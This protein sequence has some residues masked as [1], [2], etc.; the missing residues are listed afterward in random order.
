MGET[1]QKIKF[2][3]PVTLNTVCKISAVY[4][5]PKKNANKTTAVY[6]NPMYLSSFQRSLL[7]KIFITPGG[8][9]LVLLP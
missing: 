6:A 8:A 3:S 7:H 1:L 4:A 9:E 5:N 2:L